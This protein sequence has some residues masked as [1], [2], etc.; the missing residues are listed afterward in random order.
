MHHSSRHHSSAG[1]SA[2][3]SAAGASAAAG[4][5]AAGAAAGLAYLAI[6]ARTFL[7][8]LPAPFLSFA[9]GRHPVMLEMFTSATWTALPSR[10]SWPVLIFSLMC[11]LP[12]L[13]RMTFPVPVIRNRFAAAFLV[14][15]LFFEPATTSRAP[16]AHGCIC[17]GRGAARIRCGARM[18]QLPALRRWACSILQGLRLRLAMLRHIAEAIPLTS[19]APPVIVRRLGA[20][21]CYTKLS[22]TT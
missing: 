3:G 21:A 16:L 18:L 5:A 8:F 7:S 11:C 4:A 2:S 13:L 6:L 15:T 20:D 17:T 14:F 1:A 19:S 10:L 22:H 9:Y 12:G